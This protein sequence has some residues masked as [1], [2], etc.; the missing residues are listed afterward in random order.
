VYGVDPTTSTLYSPQ[1]HFDFMSYCAPAWT[2][3]FTFRGI[4]GFRAQNPQN[5]VAA[6]AEP[7]LLIWGSTGPGGL[8]LEPAFEVTT[9]PVLPDAPGDYTLG[10]GAHFAFAVPLDRVSPDRLARIRLSG[11]GQPPAEVGTAMASAPPVPFP[12]LQARRVTTEDVE[13]LWDV[14]ASRVVMVRDPATGTILSFARGGATT[15]ATGAAALELVL[16]DGVRSTVRQI[17]VR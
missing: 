9:R 7:S 6:R 2:S 11:P 17:V 5:F 3:D 4:L 1:T 8:E 10:V 15:V 13:V 12:A 14:A 16:S